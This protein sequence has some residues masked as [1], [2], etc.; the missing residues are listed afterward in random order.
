MITDKLQFVFCAHTCGKLAFEDEIQ[1]QPPLGIL[2]LGTYLKSK[3]PELEVEVIDGKSLTDEELLRSIDSEYVGFSIGFSNYEKTLKM[4]EEVKEQQPDTKILIGG[5]HTAFL[6]EKIIGNNDQ[7]DYLFSNESERQLTELIKGKLPNDI[8]GLFYRTKGK[9]FHSNSKPILQVNLD[10]VPPPDLSILIPEYR[11]TSNPE[12]HAMSAFPISGIRGCNRKNRC[13]YCSIPSIGYRTRTPKEYWRHIKTLYEEY[14]IDFLFETGDVITPKFLRDIAEYK[15]H[16]DIAMRIYSYP[17]NIRKKHLPLLKSIGVN[18]IF[19]GVES[20]LIWRKN[21]QRKYIKDYDF[22]SVVEEIEM[23]G[24]IGIRVIPS[25][26][27]GMS[28]EDKYSLEE[29]VELILKLNQLDNVN[30]ITVSVVLPLPGSKYF[31]RCLEDSIIRCSYNEIT[32]D[33][34]TKTDKIDVYLLSQLF[35]N[36]FTYI[37]YEKLYRT[38]DELNSI[39]GP[40][41]ASWGGTKPLTN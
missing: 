4:I 5:T 8:T 24:D 10:S 15:E 23:L 13:E 40:G 20:S 26:V 7:I 33:E 25:F 30:E 6:G 38:I 16:P 22:N 11:W 37:G 18:T 34:L 31:V 21:F 19:M 3:I 39:I 41:L 12:S 28:G 17:G 1:T 2:T 14:G 32:S 35:V 27:L 29:T 36:R 9:V